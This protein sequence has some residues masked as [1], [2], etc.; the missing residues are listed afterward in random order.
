MQGRLGWAGLR[1]T[2]RWVRGRWVRGRLVRGCWVEALPCFLIA[3]YVS[4]NL[5]NICFPMI[6]LLA[7][8]HRA[9]RKQRLVF[10]TF[11]YDV[12]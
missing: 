3:P 5:C 2:G 9:V 11:F 4:P 7:F 10:F 6:L 8:N 1:G 12:V